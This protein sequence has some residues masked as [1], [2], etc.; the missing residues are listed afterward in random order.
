[1][2][3]FSCF[4]FTAQSHSDGYAIKGFDVDCGC[5][6]SNVSSEF[7]IGMIIRNVILIVITLLLNKTSLLE[8]KINK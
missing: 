6:G 8:Q 3:L 4:L 7:G 2:P 5:F 1:L